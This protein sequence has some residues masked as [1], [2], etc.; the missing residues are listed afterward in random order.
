MIENAISSTTSLPMIYWK[1]FISVAIPSL[2]TAYVYRSLQSYAS[3]MCIHSNMLEV[4]SCCDPVIDINVV[5]SM[6]KI[7]CCTVPCNTAYC[8]RAGQYNI[9]HLWHLHFM[10]IVHILVPSLHLQL[11]FTPHAIARAGLS[12]RFYPS[13]IVVVIVVVCHTKILKK[14]SNGQLRGYNNF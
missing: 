11:F 12:N 2:I 14:P 9:F 1:C 8:S 10:G 4:L 13:V 7:S 6:E 3:L 5:L